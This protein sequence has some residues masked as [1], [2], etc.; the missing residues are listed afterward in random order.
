M[1]R[2]V[3]R[4]TAPWLVL[5]FIL[6]VLPIGLKS[7]YVEAEEKNFPKIVV[8]G[9]GVE[10]QLVTPPQRIFST[11]LAMD[12]ILL[13]L[14]DPARVV[15]VT[16]FALDPYGSYVVD[17]VQAHM[18]VVDQLHPELV[19][20]SAPDIVLVASWS[21]PDAV[22]QLK[23][24]GVNVYTF[25]SFDTLQDALD[26]IVRI[27]EITGD[28]DRAA[29]LIAQF[30]EAYAEIEKRVSGRDRP[31][32]L[33]YDSWGSTTGKGTSVHDIIVMAGGFNVAAEHGITGWKDIDTEAIIMMNPEVIMTGSGD[34]FVSE[35]LSD[36]ALTSVNAVKAGRIYSIDHTGALNHNFIKAIDQLARV[37]HPG[38]F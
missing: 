29:E 22:K 27:G 8:D 28:E 36:P 11:G 32:V 25:T 21:D 37:L 3:R 13:E 34:A 16:R 33:N 9:L 7:P 23:D 20:A 26:N 15:G 1:A 14:T 30:D 19:I 17:K 6:A 35:I 5:A 10:I 31:K 2:I 38:A 24:L 18:T 12:N 4:V